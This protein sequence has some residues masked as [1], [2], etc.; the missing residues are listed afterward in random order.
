MF[1][2]NAN[3]NISSSL[4]ILIPIFKLHSVNRTIYSAKQCFGWPYGWTAGRSLSKRPVWPKRNNSIMISLLFFLAC[5]GVWTLRVQKNITSFDTSNLILHHWWSPILYL[6]GLWHWRDN[7][8]HGHVAHNVLFGCMGI[9]GDWGRLNPFL[10]NFELARDLI[11]SNTL[12][13]TPNRT[14]P[15]AEYVSAGETRMLVFSSRGARRLSKGF[16]TNLFPSWNM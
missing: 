10:F 14:S 15:K 4:P 6:I 13:S 5:L 9:E 12:R 16:A 3:K 8:Y 2:A 11:P 7:L 1:T